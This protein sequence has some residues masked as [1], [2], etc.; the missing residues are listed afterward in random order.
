MSVPTKSVI[1]AFAK[2]DILSLLSWISAAFSL[3]LAAPHRLRHETLKKCARKSKRESAA[4]KD[5]PDIYYFIIIIIV[6]PN[7]SNLRN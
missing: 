7:I 5:Q 6:I 3:K 4:S 1:E 2:S